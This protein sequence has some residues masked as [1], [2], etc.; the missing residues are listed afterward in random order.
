MVNG[1]VHIIYS[2]LHNILQRTK[3]NGILSVLLP[4]LLGIPQGSVLSCLL[5]IIFIN[6]IVNVLEFSRIKLF[7]DDTL[8]YIECSPDKINETISHLN[9]DLSKIYD[10]LC[11]SKL[12]LNIAKMKAMIISSKQSV[13]A[14]TSY[15][16]I[17]NDPIEFVDSIKYLG[18]IL[19]KKLS[20][21]DQ[22]SDILKKLNK[23][24]YVFKRCESK[25]N[26]E[27]KK[28]FVQSLIFSHFNY[29]STIS[30]LFTETQI[31][32]FQKVLNR[33]MR[34]TAA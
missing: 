1:N 11:F 3:F 32:D 25:L 29:C 28:I 6:D 7:A 5:F 26:D 16:Q 12:L 33:F 20:F 30:F 22:H 24:F 27:S 18:V 31:N 4:I 19:D 23:K 2:Y 17:N 34:V 10:W 21:Q 9:S 13:P 15:I 8:I 14:Q